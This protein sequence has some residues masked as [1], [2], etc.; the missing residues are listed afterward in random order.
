MQSIDQLIKPSPDL[1]LSGV[2]WPLFY[3]S[4]SRLTSRPCWKTLRWLS[5]TLRRSRSTSSSLKG[6]LWW[7]VCSPLRDI[8]IWSFTFHLTVQMCLMSTCRHASII[9]SG[10]H[11]PEF[12]GVLL[13][14]ELLLLPAASQT[15]EW[16]GD[17]DLSSAFYTRYTGILVLNLSL[18]TMQKRDYHTAKIKYRL[19]F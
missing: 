15:E 10:G 7:P 19:S 12:K 3:I 6:S 16:R 13:P 4:V 11:T 2:S 17:Q 14:G 9:P 8:C 5:L 1:F 18:V